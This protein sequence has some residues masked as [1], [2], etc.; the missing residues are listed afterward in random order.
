MVKVEMFLNDASC[1]EELKFM[2]TSLIP[3]FL[4][5]IKLCSTFSICIIL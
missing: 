4:Y 1:N 2:Y 3:L 5:N